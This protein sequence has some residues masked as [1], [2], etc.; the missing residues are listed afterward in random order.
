MKIKF[1]VAF[2]LFSFISFSQKE[3]TLS[4]A[5]LQQYRGF[6]PEHIVG[7]AWIPT[8]SEYSYLEKYTTLVKG[9][10]GKKETTVLLT[11]KQLNEKAGV[12]FNYFSGFEWLSKDEF[13]VNDGESFVL[14][15]LVTNTAKSWQIKGENA[16]M[17]WKNKAIAYTV[18]NNVYLDNKGKKIAVTNHKSKEIIAGQTI[19][20]NEFNTNNGLFWSE[21]G[22]FLAFYEKDESEIHNYPLL[23][24]D[25][26]P[27]E[28][29]SIKY[30][31]AGQKSEKSAV[32]IYDITTQNL[33]YIRPQGSEDDYLT[34]I[35][36]SKDEKYLV[37]AALNR[38]Q[39]HLKVNLYD[40][41]T[42]TFIRTL[43]EEQNSK[44]VEPEF[45]TYFLNATDFIWVSERDGFMNLYLYDINGKLKSQLTKN[46]FPVKEIIGT[47]PK[48]DAIYFSATGSKAINTLVYKVDL[49]GKQTLLTTTEGTHDVIFSTNYFFDQYSSITTPNV[50]AIYD[51]AGKEKQRL[52]TGINKL[53]DYKLGKTIVQTIPVNGIEEYARIIYPSD[54]DSTKKYPVL[55]YVYG[56]PHAQ[57]ITNSWYA[58]AN[59]WMNWMAEQGYI[60]F[61]VDSRGSA[62]RG[63]EFESVIHRELGTTEM[64]DQIA[65]LEW[66]K[67][68]SYIDGNR[69][70]VHGW[71][72]GGFMTTNLMLTYPNEFKVGVAG[73]PVTN[74]ALYEVMYGE[75]Y[76]DRPEQN[77]EGYEKTDLS[78]KVNTLKGKLLLI[79][80]TVDDVVVMQHNLRLVK[81]FVE[82]GKQMDFFPYPMH[83][84]N[85]MGKDRVHLMTKVLNYI[86]ENNK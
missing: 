5:V 7:F 60:I 22:N 2:I 68:K 52:L 43:F 79:H 64:K 15:N 53:A 67:K 24:I 63:F 33:V 55:V 29:K 75:R 16:L 8:T 13:A 44:W 57:L 11:I 48:N 20:R 47:S 38:D 78:K 49:K 83:L 76:M 77:K 56:G 72:F 82:A 54:F 32:G 61:T 42:G 84:H 70:A 9:T 51:L 21:N 26:I 59:L 39:N 4:D 50:A 14:Y 86:L 46:Q 3:L 1:L 28:L 36:F 40:V 34:N 73:G 35:S 71:S 45:P 41:K 58:G 25:S 12:E 74:W 81:A 69:I 23:N 62:N 31:M 65:A 85:V 27:G 37:I 30:P 10:V 66:L 80:G 6:Y 17:N 19:A 18:E